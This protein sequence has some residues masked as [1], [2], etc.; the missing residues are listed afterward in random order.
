MV[1]RGTTIGLVSTKKTQLGINVNDLGTADGTIALVGTYD[2]SK[3]TG[4]DAKLANATK[5]TY[6]LSLQERAEDGSYRTVDGD[7][8]KYLQVKEGDKL[9]TGTVSGNTIVFTDEKKDGKFATLD[10]DSLA[11]KHRFVVKVNTD[12]E[13]SEETYANYRLVLT[14]HMEGGGV[15]DTPKGATDAATDSDFV[16]YTITKVKMDGIDHSGQTN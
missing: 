9:G 12:V 16:T 3:L 4:A 2:L 15:N 13:G 5:V 11:F 14:A 8:S 6:T 1:E 7:I 10:G